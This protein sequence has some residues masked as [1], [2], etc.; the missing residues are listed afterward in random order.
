MPG[1]YVYAPDRKSDRPVQHLKGFT[2]VLQVDGYA[3]YPRTHRQR[4]PD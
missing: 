2:G 1:T 4:S 3:G